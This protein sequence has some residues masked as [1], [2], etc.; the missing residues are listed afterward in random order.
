M[1]RYPAY[2]LIL[3]WNHCLCSQPLTRN[4]FAIHRLENLFASSLF[5]EIMT[6]LDVWMEV[7][8]LVCSKLTPKLTLLEPNTCVN[9]EV[10]KT[11]TNSNTNI[12]HPNTAIG[13]DVCLL[14]VS[15][16]STLE[17][18]SLQLCSQPLTSNSFP[19]VLTILGTF[20]A[21]IVLLILSLPCFFNKK[22]PTPIDPP[23]FKLLPSSLVDL[24]LAIRFLL[25]I[26]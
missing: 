20:P 5:L 24:D 8:V 12:Y 16:N 21:V 17:S 14:R 11:T 18:L 23:H 15:F 6:T 1:F 3:H 26:Q 19:A 7:L 10:L 2:H 13:D 9:L 4:S 25:L 22:A